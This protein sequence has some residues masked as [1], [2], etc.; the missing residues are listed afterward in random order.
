MRTRHAAT[1]V[2]A[3][4]TLV[5]LCAVGRG[6]P[7]PLPKGTSEF[8]A[9]VASMAEAPTEEQQEE[10][11][12]FFSEHGTYVIS[13]A[14]FDV[15]FAH[16]ATFLPL[17]GPA[18]HPCVREWFDD[19]FV[20][21]L[22]RESLPEERGPLVEALKPWLLPGACESGAVPFDERIAAAEVLSDY[23]DAEVAPLVRHLMRELAGDGIDAMS[24]KGL[25][26]WWYLRH[27]L[28]R[29][30]APPGAA[31]VVHD[32]NGGFRV[33]PDR[34]AL[35]GAS[36][37]RWGFSSDVEPLEAATAGQ[38]LDLIESAG[39]FQGEPEAREP[40]EITIR[41]GDG[42]EL[43]VRTFEGDGVT[44]WDNTRLRRREIYLESAELSSLVRSLVELEDARTFPSLWGT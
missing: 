3:M 31:A 40:G 20:A 5:L 32:G 18:Y 43:Y 25:T 23:G 17:V 16:P 30:E 6:N 8:N 38:V 27:V 41:F 11:V 19:M 12:T 2:G 1:L 33:A 34:S 4:V 26:R 39:A 9:M 15:M 7:A 10:F 29:L 44:V 13:G 36:F 42:I 28:L 21:G 35:L 22:L 24:G 14:S 37:C